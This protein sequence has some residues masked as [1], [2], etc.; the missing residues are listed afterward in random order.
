MIIHQVGTYGE[1][2]HAR[3]VFG[4]TLRGLCLLAVPITVALVLAVL[5]A[6]ALQ[7][8]TNLQDGTCR[9]QARGLPGSHVQT[10]LWRDI[11]V[12]TRPAPG[13]APKLPPE[14][15]PSEPY[16]YTF[17]RHGQEVTVTL[18][19]RYNPAYFAA[20][21]FEEELPRYNRIEA[22]LPAGRRC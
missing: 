13:A 18:H 15:I 3:P 10:T 12:L 20:I 5:G 19:Q 4:F 16:A 1:N 6:G 14:I 22:A 2:S 17:K 11:A 8:A 9:I 21:S 7:D